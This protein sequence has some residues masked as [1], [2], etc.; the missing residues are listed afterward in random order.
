MGDGSV[1]SVYMPRLHKHNAQEVLEDA[2]DGLRWAERM[3]IAMA[4][5]GGKGES[6][7]DEC[8]WYEHVARE[9]PSLL[10]CYADNAVRRFVANNMIQFPDDCQ[11]ELE[12]V[13]G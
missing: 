12:N 10:E 4:A 6:V 7:K 11:D 5:S 3:L 1:V 8:Y 9:V 2:E 13:E